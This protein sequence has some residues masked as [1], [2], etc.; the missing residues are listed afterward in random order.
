MNELTEKEIERLERKLQEAI[1]DKKSY[2]DLA[3]YHCEPIGTLCETCCCQHLNTIFLPWH[4][5]YMV[6]FEEMLD[7]AL[8]YW[9]WTEDTEKPKL[10]QNIRVPFKEGAQSSVPVE[11]LQA[12]SGLVNQEDP[13]SLLNEP[14]C[15]RG[16]RSI[17]R[18]AENV[19]WNTAYLKSLVRNAFQEEEYTK[20]NGII[21]SPHN[22][23]HTTAGCEMRDTGTAS[24]DP[25]F[26]LNHAYVDRQL[27]FWEELNR[28]RGN[29]EIGT[30]D[31]MD[32]K[33]APFDNEKYNNVSMT[34]DNSQSQNV[35]D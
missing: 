33:L 20:Y 34:I 15:F 26:W 32:Q 16:D 12:Q 17:V 10:W 25:I 31:L 13:N 9:D 8:P 21:I 11:G 30:F 6:N 24:Y 27:A 22:I 14:S 4:R 18:R 29:T 23:V 3:N 35:F 1:D 28:L 19:T 2:H 7:E 5:L